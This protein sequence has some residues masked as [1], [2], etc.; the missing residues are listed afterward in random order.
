M[1][2]WAHK[3]WVHL[4]DGDVLLFTLILPLIVTRI[5]LMVQNWAQHAFIDEE[6]PI[7]NFRSSLTNCRFRRS[8]SPTLHNLSSLIIFLRATAMALTTA[9][10]SSLARSPRRLSRSHASQHAL[11]FC[12]INYVMLTYRLFRKDY[13]Y[14]PTCLVPMAI[15]IQMSHGETVEML[16]SK[17]TKL[18]DDDI[19]RR[20]RKEWVREGLGGWIWHL[21]ICGW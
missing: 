12:N 13:D 19:K 15:R 21:W 9:T 3:L 7:S 20:F 2:I 4:R 17:M 1:H 14:L 16:R 6:D 10:T 8:H 11:V 5:G 18:T